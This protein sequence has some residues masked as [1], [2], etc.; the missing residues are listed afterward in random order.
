MELPLHK[1][2]NFPGHEVPFTLNLDI[3]V[4]L[5]GGRRMPLQTI[6]L[7]QQIGNQQFK[8]TKTYDTSLAREAFG[9]MDS[10]A[11]DHLISSLAIKQQY[12]PNE[13]P[14]PI[15]GAPDFLWNELCQSARDDGQKCPFVVVTRTSKSA[16]SYLYVSRD[17]P[18]AENFVRGFVTS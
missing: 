8:I 17:W 14:A 1:P 6:F 11:L 2:N 3:V 16:K 12:Q 15:I 10:S 7:S 9:D 13:I 4:T 18:S 5:S